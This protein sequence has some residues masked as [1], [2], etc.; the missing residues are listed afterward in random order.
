MSPLKYS[1]QMEL[2]P[3]LR[4]LVVVAR[5]PETAKVVTSAPLT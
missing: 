2:P 3:I 1:P 4:G 5:L